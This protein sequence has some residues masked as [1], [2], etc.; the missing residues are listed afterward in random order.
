MKDLA[1]LI[2]HLSGTTFQG[3]KYE[4]FHHKNSKINIVQTKIYFII[5]S[6]TSQKLRNFIYESMGKKDVTELAGIGPVLKGILCF[7]NV[8]RVKQR[9]QFVYRMDEKCD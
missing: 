7:G 9:L 2:L 8:S 6:N 1:V 4:F 5:L 3:P